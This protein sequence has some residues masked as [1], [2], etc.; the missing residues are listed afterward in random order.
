MVEP[1]SCAFS[2][3]SGTWE[4]GVS[5]GAYLPVFSVVELVTN[6]NGDQV[7]TGPLPFSPA[8]ARAFG[9]CRGNSGFSAIAIPA[10]QSTFDRAPMECKSH[11]RSLRASRVFPKA[12]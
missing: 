1:L 11:E 6:V 9:L 7:A 8:Y 4:V 5:F 10:V 3:C 2:L 12:A